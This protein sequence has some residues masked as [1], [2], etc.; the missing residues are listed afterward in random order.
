MGLRQWKG[1][2]SRWKG[3]TWVGKRGE[4]EGSDGAWEAGRGGGVEGG[5]QERR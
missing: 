2:E 1:R 3:R 4:A 5:V